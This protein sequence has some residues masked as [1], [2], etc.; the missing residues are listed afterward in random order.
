MAKK[1]PKYEGG[2]EGFDK[3]ITLEVTWDLCVK[4]VE[5]KRVY[6]AETKTF[7]EEMCN[8]G[9]KQFPSQGYCGVFPVSWRKMKLF[10]QSLKRG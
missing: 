6:P 8:S 10:E 9:W 4:L 5:A 2:L 7:I 3:A 1:G